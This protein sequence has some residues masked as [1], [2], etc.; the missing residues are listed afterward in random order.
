MTGTL[1]LWKKEYLWISLPDA[2][3]ELRLSPADLDAAIRPMQKY[4]DADEL[5]FV[6]LGS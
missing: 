3:Q 6:Q 5:S 2:R 4:Y 1:L